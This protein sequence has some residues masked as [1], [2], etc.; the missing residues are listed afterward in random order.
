M[1]INFDN[2]GKISFKHKVTILV[3]VRCFEVQFITFSGL[4][5]P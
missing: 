3:I 4:I 5:W 1:N 2:Y